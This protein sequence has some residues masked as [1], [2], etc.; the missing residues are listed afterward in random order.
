M[1]RATQA[2]LI[3]DAVAAHV[4]WMCAIAQATGGRVWREDSLLAVHQ[5]LP[6]NEVLLP[7]PAEIPPHALERVVEWARAH[8]VRMIGCWGR[9]EDAPAPQGFEE[10]WRPH[11]MAGDAAAGEPDPRV[12]QT[13]DVPE[14]DAYGQALLKAMP[15]SHFIARVDGGFAGM[16]WRHDGA[17]FD[18]F[19]PEGHRRRGLGSALTRAVCAH[20]PVV[21]NAT[22]DGECLYRAL[23]FESLGYGRTWWLRA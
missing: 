16:A 3:D 17:M 4:S 6:H 8:R 12:A 18:L 19:V 11:W 10:G 14:Y 7:F 21:L 5:P 13:D 15:G 22:A 9:D 23:G 1:A 2:G 20:G